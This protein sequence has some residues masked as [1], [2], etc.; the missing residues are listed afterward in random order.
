MK[1]VA[2]SLTK[3]DLSTI[4]NWN[5]SARYPGCSVVPRTALKSKS[6]GRLAMACA[7]RATVALTE[8]AVYVNPPAWLCLNSAATSSV[9]TKEAGDSGSTTIWY[10]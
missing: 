4:L 8:V 10:R 2:T 9:K 6:A 7:T 3:P 1:T 5:E